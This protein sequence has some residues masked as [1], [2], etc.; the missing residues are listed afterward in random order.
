MTLTLV[1]VTKT[2]ARQFVQEKHRHNE[3]PSPAQ[4]SFAVGVESDGQLVGVATAGHPVARMLDD[5]FTVEI[6]RVCTDGTPHAASMLYGAVVRA[7]KALGYRRAVTYTLV[8]EPGTSLK[9]AGWVTSVPIGARSWQ[10]DNNPD[11]R[12]RMDVTIWGE[13]RNAA[14]EPKQRWERT[15]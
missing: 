5:G 3:A 2:L 9:A 13:R 14:N 4:V 12:P 11:L 1:P 8:S 15:L 7:A 6:N 10:D